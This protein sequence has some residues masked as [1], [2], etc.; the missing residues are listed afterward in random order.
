MK[1]AAIITAAGIG[2]RM[3]AG[4]PKQYLE[5]AGKP[6]VVHTIERF[7]G[8]DGIEQLIVTV[9]PGDEASFESD[10]AKPLGLS[11]HVEVVAG[12]ERRQDSVR[13]GLA[14]VADGIDVVL[15]HDGVRPFIR[16]E[17]IGEAMRAAQ[18][19]GACI[20]AMPLKET[21]K[22]VDGSEYIDQ[23]VDRAPLWGAQTPQSFRLDVIRR[24]FEEA[25]AADFVGTDDAMLVER[26]GKP[27]KVIRGDYN[28]IKITTKED[29]EIA[30]ILAKKDY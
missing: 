19:E 4:R 10:I 27:V 29:L 8:A 25:D 16:R 24:A 21:I 18:D 1:A 5:V 26:I 23:T 20:V 28:N 30:E 15:I 7:M 14:R 17:T 3:G 2:K 13:N 9:P 11:E 12:G 6:I 22:F